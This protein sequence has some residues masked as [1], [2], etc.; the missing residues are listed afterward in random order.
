VANTEHNDS[1]ELAI[2]F[3]KIAREYKSR[4]VQVID[5]RGKSPA[6]YF[7]VIATCRSGRQARTVADEINNCSKQMGHSRFGQAG[8]EAGK[9]VLLDFVDV[10]VHIF[11]EEYR[12]YY[13]LEKLWGDAEF[14]KF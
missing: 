14:L 11:D 5:L 10:V 6:T 2:Q 1:K 4:D 7:F 9:W 8:Y 12:E 3:A 13:Q